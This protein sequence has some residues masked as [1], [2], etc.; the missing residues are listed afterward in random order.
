MERLIYILDT[1]AVTD[2]MGDAAPTTTH[3]RQAIQNG[4]FVA[5]CLPVYYELLR[6]LLKAGA[7]RKLHILHTKVMPRLKWY[8]LVERDWIQAARYWANATSQGRQLSDI[9]LLIAAL[10]VRLSAVIVSSD[11]DF[12]VLPVRRENWREPAT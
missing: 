9:D 2:Y 1:N 10:A 12:D 6:G 5:L 8:S 11:A 3:I 4:H 7:S